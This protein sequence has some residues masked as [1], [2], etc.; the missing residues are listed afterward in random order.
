MAI[1]LWLVYLNCKC[2]N[3][4]KLP[5]I[6][7]LHSIDDNFYCNAFASKDTVNTFL[8]RVCAFLLIHS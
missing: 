6:K 3:Q 4:R 8:S 2:D 7:K 1:L 5:L